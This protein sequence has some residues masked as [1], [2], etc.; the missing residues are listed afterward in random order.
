MNFFPR[1][2]VAFLTIFGT[3]L[4]ARVVDAQVR[5]VKL[6]PARTQIQFTL[7][8]VLH[9]VH[10]TFQLKSGEIRFDPTTGIADGAVIVD[11]TSGNS[12]S[13]DRDKKMH[14]EILESWRYPEISFLPRKVTGTVSLQD[15]A[16][17]QVQGIFRMHGSDHNLT[18]TIPIQ[19]NSNQLSATTQFEVPYVAWGLKNP[20]TFILRVSNKVQISIAA[21]GQVVTSQTRQQLTTP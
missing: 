11:A 10:G 4:T 12:G 5:I 7:K 20:S 17:V 3:L 2:R 13:S 15:A 19:I 9:T 6:E 16:Q 14:K 8:D 18:L 1:S 21:S